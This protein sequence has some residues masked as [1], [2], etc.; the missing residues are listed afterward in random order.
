MRVRAC[1][2]ATV[3]LGVYRLHPR[4]ARQRRALAHKTFTMR[5]AGTRTLRLAT[6][7]LRTGR[8][9]LRA[10]LKAAKPKRLSSRIAILAPRRSAGR[11]R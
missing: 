6:R 5:V 2:K 9:A 8:F 10:T 11:A 4:T 1:G 3:T 7:R